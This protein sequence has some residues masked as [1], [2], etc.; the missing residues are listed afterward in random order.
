MKAS[1][2][3]DREFVDEV[4]ALIRRAG[5]FT[6]DYFESADLRT[7]S[8]FDGTPV[9]DA[10]R[11]AERLIRQYI[12]RN[13]PQDSVLGEEEG[14]SPGSS[15]RTWY[16]DP[17]DGTKAFTRGVPLYSNLISVEDA[18]GPLVAAINIPALREIV[19]AGRGL[20]CW[21]N[22]NRAH[23]SAHSEL[24]GS[25]MMTSAYD[26]WPT[27]TLEATRRARMNMRTWG[28]GYGYAL[29]ATGRAEIMFDPIAAPWD[30]APMPLVIAEAGG[31]F[32]DLSGERRI[33]GGSGVATNTL[34]HAAALELLDEG[35]H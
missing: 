6:L 4:V 20:G 33:D 5:Q 13:Y 30:L 15:D 1:P 22:D 23:V 16:V 21:R 25:Y 12:E 14:H 19:Y 27:S 28:D 9:T 11:G 2:P 7:E 34:V 29:V 31:T 10:D 17:I 18:H 35:P 3:A 32:T 8:K 26:D 24:A